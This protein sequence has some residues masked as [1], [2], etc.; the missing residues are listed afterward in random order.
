M[1]EQ[2]G[3]KQ[4]DQFQDDSAP[5]A[6]NQEQAGDE[7]PGAADD[8]PQD[9]WA[10][11]RELYEH[12]PAAV[13]GSLVGGDQTGVSG[14]S[15][16]GDVILGTKVEHHYRFGVST[17]TSGN[18]PSA[19]LDQ[20]AMVFA[21][22]EE[23]VH[24]LRDRLHD[25]RVL[26]LS[27]APFTG[28]RSGALMLLRA[29]GAEHIRAVDPNTRPTA[30]RD[31]LNGDAPGYL[32]SDLVTCRENPLR[33]IDLWAAGDVLR[34]KGAY[35]VVTVDLFA[36]LHGVPVVAWRP[37]SPQAVLRSHLHASVQNP[38]RENELL[39]LDVSRRFLARDDHQLREAAVFAE[40]LAAHGDG[41][42]TYQELANVGPTLVRGQVEEWFGENETRLRDKAFLISLAAFDE[43]AY[44]LTAELSD[45]LYAQFQR[46]EDGGREPRVGIFGTSITARLNLARA[47]EYW[48]E[49]HTEWGPVR[50]RMA[51]FQEPA[52]AGEVL[53]EVWTSH[54]SARPALLAWL[55]QLA[56]DGRPLV[57]TRAAVTAAVL[58]RTDL[59]SAMALLIEGW[60]KSKLY[61]DR[62]VAANALA[63]AH[64]VDAPNIPQILRSWCDEE[65]GP[66][67]RWTAIRAYALV[68]PRMPDE[69]LE[70]LAEAIHTGD[71]EEEAQHIAESVALLLSDE[72]APVR[73]HVL[74]GLLDFL[75]VG[76]SG[77][78]LALHAFV[79]ACT[80]ADSRLLLRWYA[81]AAASGT[82]DANRLA[83]LWRT[84]LADLSYTNDA[85]KALAGWILEADGDPRAERELTMLLPTLVSSD[86]DRKRLDHML[87]TLRGRHRG[88]PP[89]V[90]D[91]LA[92]VL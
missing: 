9:P 89:A 5:S 61:R 44:A 65:A 27:G 45:A 32:I 88:D 92:A 17:R 84:A 42:M 8:R 90:A 57:R 75:Q 39:A 33:D 16:A 66:R 69:A 47:V 72:S 91:R 22:Y 79:L 63:M 31:E 55:R 10:A 19:E 18:I 64:A 81:E 11:R 68:G 85:L 86:A 14:G 30:L 26:V 6:D 28:R 76:A 21:G 87:R 83:S 13:S 53:R 34:E 71:D 24:P 36:T 50:Q 73:S 43:A 51:R 54:P 56:Q 12:V 82:E 52:A 40:N 78:R 38:R 7:Q 41:T 35:L 4:A 62:L 67:L 58:A 1:S 25:E 37:P 46:T 49:E 29:L 3:D 70:A 15:V 80:R 60:A 2:P 23:R 20:L 48:K 59:P 77:R 74:Q